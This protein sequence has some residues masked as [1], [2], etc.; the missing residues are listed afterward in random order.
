[1]RLVGATASADPLL[2]VTHHLRD[3]FSL[4]SVAVLT[5]T[6][7]GWRTEAASGIDPPTDPGEADETI[8]L[9]DGVLLAL[10][11]P[12]IAAE[13]RHVMHA[14]ADQLGGALR[15]RE[16]GRE[17]AAAAELLEGRQSARYDAA[18]RRRPR[19][20][21]SKHATRTDGKH[22]RCAG[23]RSGKR[24][25]ATSDRQRISVI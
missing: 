24:H 25:V 1:M 19:N 13:D 7:D 14:F 3:A 9:G 2:T 8:D 5:K 22:S 10:R 23:G 12:E 18:R 6:S 15:S 17:A 11:G 4:E 20:D 16:L 21:S